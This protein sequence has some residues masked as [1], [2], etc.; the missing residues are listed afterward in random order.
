MEKKK[1]FL[2]IAIV[3]IVLLLIAAVMALVLLLKSQ[4]APVPTNL[5]EA[6]PIS[7]TTPGVLP[8]T[9]STNTTANGQ[10]SGQAQTLQKEKQFISSYYQPV[11]AGYQA[12]ELGVTFPA[13]YQQLEGMQVDPDT[14][15]IIGGIA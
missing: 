12:T 3:V 13:T 7:A 2:V 10:L 6:A 11:D 8:T 5:N 14:G 15:E 4:R 1:L 9:P